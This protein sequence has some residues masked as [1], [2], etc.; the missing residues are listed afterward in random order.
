LA[1]V[2]AQ[3][4]TE[5]GADSELRSFEQAHASV[6][7]WSETYSSAQAIPTD[8]VPEV[9]DLRNVEGNDFTGAVRDQERCGSCYALSFIQSIESRLKM[10]YGKDIPQLSVQQLLSCNYLNEGCEGGWAMFNGYFAENA[11]LITQDCGPYR[12]STNGDKCK[13]YQQCPAYAKISDS[14]FVEMSM[15][16]NSVNE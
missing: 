8:K 4:Q 12:G 7:S 9:Y 3:S 6:R 16:E 14:Q 11:H 2:D 5:E 10:K 13:F 15:T 1:Q